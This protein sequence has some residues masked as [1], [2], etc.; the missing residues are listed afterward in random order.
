MA[1][2]KSCTTDFEVTDADKKVHELMKVPAPKLCPNCRQQRRISF[3]ND[4][5]YYKN[6]CHLCKKPTISIYSPDKPL[7]VLCPDC[8]WSDKWS[9]L[10]YGKDYD[11]SRP[12]FEQY[13]EMRAEVPRLAIFNTQ[14]E[15]SEFTVHSSKNR[16]C[17]I[18]SS[19]VDCEDVMYTDWGF[20]CKD[21]MDMLF[22]SR[23]EMCFETV[24]SQDCNLSNYLELCENV[25]ESFYAFDCKSSTR[26]VG[27][28]G[29]RNRK[30]HILNQPASKEECISTIHRLKTDPEFKKEFLEKYKALQ[31]KAP[32]MYAWSTNVENCSGNYIVD[33]KNARHAYNVKDIEDARYIYEAKDVKDGYDCTRI[34]GGEFLYECKGAVDLKYGKFTNLCYQ[35]DNIAY[36]DNCQGSSNV[37]GGMSLKQNSYV[38]LNKQYSK[39]EYTELVPKIIEHM[40]E[41]EEWGEFFPIEMSPFGY[42]ET[43]AME[44]FPMEKEEVRKKG[45]KWSDYEAPLPKDIKVI[46]ARR[47][48]DNISDVPDD[49]LNWAIECEETNKPFKIQ[50]RELKFY[51]QKG[52][53]IPHLSPKAR[54]QRRASLQNP[55]TLYDRKCDKCEKAIKTTYAE[56]RP[57][58]VYC[59]PCYLLTVY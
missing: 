36:S 57:E 8:F 56:D 18:G 33:S 52:L 9:P 2:C 40:K 34:G 17:Y 28:V 24:D 14:S 30:N 42:N 13:A 50:S 22:C 16:N 51:R 20:N 19:L 29:L 37:F 21:S 48:P 58:S 23:M 31:L 26:L 44:W 7:K 38:I 41:T 46:P 47:V 10:D 49:I 54:H 12:F 59:E 25:Q 11:F 32:K 3:R 15:N 55:R 43:K 35:S 53:P 1:N 27:C 6:E 45:W 5:N 4:S 39:Q